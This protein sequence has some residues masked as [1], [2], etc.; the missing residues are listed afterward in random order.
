M[1]DPHVINVGPRPL[2]KFPLAPYNVQLQSGA[3]VRLVPIH[4]SGQVSIPL[5]G[6]LTQE[7]ND[8][9]CTPGMMELSI[10]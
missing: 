10:D 8:E 7:M 9:V 6:Y 2:E 4:D 5:V 3:T 1:E